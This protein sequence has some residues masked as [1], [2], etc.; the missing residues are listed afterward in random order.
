MLSLLVFAAA[1]VHII[2]FFALLLLA[3]ICAVRVIGW[4]VGLPLGFEFRGAASGGTTS[5][6]LVVQ[7]STVLNIKGRLMLVVLASF[8]RD[9]IFINTVNNS[10]IE[11]V[12]VIITFLVKKVEENLFQVRIVR[13]ILEAQTAA[14]VKIV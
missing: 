1:E 5:W 9:R 3:S 6:G 11:N 8:H 14:I 10:P 12:I 2:H 7:R 4:F 13:L